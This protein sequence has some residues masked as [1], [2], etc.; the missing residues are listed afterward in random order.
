M[1]LRSP[2]SVLPG[3]L[4][5]FL[6][7]EPLDG[8]KYEWNDGEIIRFE[9]MKKKHLFL[10]RKLQQLFFRTS[11]FSK[12]AALIMEQDVMLTGI[13]LRRPDLAFF[14][15][16]QIDNSE[17]SNQEPIPE[18]VIE[19]IS[20]N[21]DAEQVEEKLAEYFLAAVRVVWHIYPENEVVYVYTSRKNVKICTDSDT[22][23]AAPIVPDFEITVEQLFSKNPS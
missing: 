22:C 16:T 10:I 14:S 6:Q 18:F 19:V 7:W 11:S 3:S 17:S 8:F 12:G 9:K 23:S 5:A 1:I 21:D 2:S 15:G 13:Q 20:P 4:E